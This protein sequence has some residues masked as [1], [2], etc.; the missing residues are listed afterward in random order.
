MSGTGP[1]MS[2]SDTSARV[3][4]G[5]RSARGLGPAGR[6]GSGASGLPAGLAN[7][8]EDVRVQGDVVCDHERAGFEL[9]P[10][11]LKELFVV[12]VRRVQEHDV[13]HVVD[14]RQRLAGVALDEVGPILES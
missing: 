9:A 12:R 2:D 8:P 7:T 14:R 11:E 13:E 6:S 4:E 3:T 1:V 10:R 5:R